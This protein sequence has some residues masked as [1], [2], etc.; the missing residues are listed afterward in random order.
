MAQLGSNV[1]SPI[2]N[3]T[4]QVSA[5]NYFSSGAIPGWVYANVYG[6]S[7][8]IGMTRGAH[9]LALGFNWTHTQMNGNGPF[10]MNPRMTFNGQLT[11]NSLADFVTGSLDTMLQGNGQVSRD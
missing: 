9:Q 8:D 2:Q 7:D 3:Y 10:Q 6:L 5:T 11:G 4:G 1:A